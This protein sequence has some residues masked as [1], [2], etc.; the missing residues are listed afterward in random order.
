MANLLMNLCIMSMQCALLS[1][2][3]HLEDRGAWRMTKLLWLTA[4][5][6]DEI[7]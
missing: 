6:D 2:K 3:L 5:A 4:T 7:C 1:I